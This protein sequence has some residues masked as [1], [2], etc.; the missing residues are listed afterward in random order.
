M[1]S[2][3]RVEGENKKSLSR[4]C[5]KADCKAHSAGQLEVVVGEE[6]QVEGETK[7]GRSSSKL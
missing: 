3:W 7:L 6:N 4:V 5:L 2:E 1:Q